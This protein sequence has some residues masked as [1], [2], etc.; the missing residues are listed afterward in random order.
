MNPA[1]LGA[2]GVIACL[3]MVACGSAAASGGTT[4][5]PSSSAGRGGFA[6]NATFGQLVQINGPTLILSG[7]NGDS[8][9][10][11]ASTTTITQTSTGTVADIIAGSC[12]TA[13]G[14]KGGD[15]TLTAATVTLSAPVNNSC[16][17]SGFGG[18][19][20]GGTGTGSPRPSF[21]G[22]AHGN[23]AER[24]WRDADHGHRDHRRA[25]NREN[26]HLVGRAVVGAADRSVRHCHRGQGRHRH[27]DRA[28][29]HHHTCRR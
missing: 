19:G 17:V 29:A 27:G 15:G 22:H 6:R 20:G 14:T 9:V 24:V 16:A 12:I 2:T 1:I 8:T 4:P 13:T 23:D 25:D 26:H 18:F 11:Y 10:R 28:F 5:T 21:V 3:G 7:T